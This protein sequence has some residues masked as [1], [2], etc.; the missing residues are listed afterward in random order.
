MSVNF[1]LLRRSLVAAFAVALMSL[2]AFGQQDARL[3]GVVRDAN[4]A[5][6]PNAAVTLRAPALAFE[7]TT[8]T[9]DD[10]IYIFQQLRPG[11]YELT[12]AQTGFRAT[13]VP[14]LAL[15]ASQ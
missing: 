11:T 3:E 8:T 9:T 14:D 2:T 13:Q 7:R 5:A 1:H 4:G 10:G 15:G 6:V 12:V